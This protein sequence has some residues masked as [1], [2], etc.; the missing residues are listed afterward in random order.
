MNRYQVAMI[1]E[2]ELT[3]GVTVSFVNRTG[4]WVLYLLDVRSGKVS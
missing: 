2:T 3:W 1:L 4:P